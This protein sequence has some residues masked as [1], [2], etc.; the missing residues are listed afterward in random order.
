M[1]PQLAANIV[2]LA[3][4]YAMVCTGYVLIYRVS[5]VFNLA[6]G[7]LLALGAY[8]LVTVAGPFN[9]S[10]V[11][12]VVIAAMLALAMGVLI[13]VFLMRWMT[14]RSVLAAVLVT[15]AF[16][17]FLRGL[18]TLIWTPQPFY[19][20]VAFN[21]RMV[22][23]PVGFGAR[24]SST[25]LAMLVAAIVVYC[26]LIAF[27]RFTRWGIQ[28]RAAG[29]NPL[30]AEQRGVR[31]HAIYAFAWGLST[32]TA[33]IAGI[34]LAFNSGVDPTISTIGLKAFPAALVGG[35]DSFAGV[36]V[37]S[38]IVATAEVFAIQFVNPLLSDV[39]PFIVLLIALTIRPWGLLG[40]RELLDRV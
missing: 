11:I 14:G 4:G 3:A 28:M 29:Q 7:D 39:V 22:S 16:G 37:G 8:F 33:G 18:M 25:N 36:L 20:A 12:A 40:S 38:I 2:V 34:I 9:K 27:L 26:G 32:F 30:L 19:P 24:V 21:W 17:F 10:P 31:L 5:R 23:V 15:V 35:L 6:H 1:L 13:Y